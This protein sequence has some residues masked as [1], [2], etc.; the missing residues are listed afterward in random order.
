[1]G[2]LGPWTESGPSARDSPPATA[3]SKDA[4]RG[5]PQIRHGLRSPGAGSGDDDLMSGRRSLRTR[6]LFWVQRLDS[7]PHVKTQSAHVKTQSGQIAQKD[8]EKDLRLVETIVLPPIE[9][10]NF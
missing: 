5:S 9:R 1:M 2:R 3:L 4:P 6:G 10:K 8:S 7:P